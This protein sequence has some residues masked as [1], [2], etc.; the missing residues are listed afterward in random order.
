MTVDSDNMGINHSLFHSLNRSPGFGKHKE[1]NNHFN[2]G[3]ANDVPKTNKVLIATT[4][5]IKFGYTK[6]SR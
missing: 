5:A 3:N 2:G 4:P 1:A 6:L